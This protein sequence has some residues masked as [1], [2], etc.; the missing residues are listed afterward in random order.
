MKTN[1]AA[2]PLPLSSSHRMKFSQRLFV[3][4][5]GLGWSIGNSIRLYKWSPHIH[6]EVGWM[7][8]RKWVTEW[9]RG[10]GA[11]S[12]RGGGGGGGAVA[13]CDMEWKREMPKRKRCQCM[14]TFMA[15]TQVKQLKCVKIR[16]FL[17][18]HFLVRLYLEPSL[19]NAFI[20]CFFCVRLCFFSH[21]FVFFSLA[22]AL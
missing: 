21:F 6:A 1:A 20:F 7:D 16:F 17:L 15:K 3:V 9:K 2:L 5:N 19:A 10:S 11:G 18:V 4:L 8:G 12:R 22:F 13:G 14:Y